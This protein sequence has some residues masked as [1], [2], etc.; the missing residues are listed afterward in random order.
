MSDFPFD[1][2]QAEMKHNFTVVES[3]A[4]KSSFLTSSVSSFEYTCMNVGF[5]DRKASG[6]TEV[7]GAFRVEIISAQEC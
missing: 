5:R 4:F 3:H 1:S 6:V 7:C 2:V